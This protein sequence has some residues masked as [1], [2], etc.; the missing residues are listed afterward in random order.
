MGAPGVC[1]DAPKEASVESAFLL[2]ASAGEHCGATQEGGK[3]CCSGHK[4]AFE[5][6]SL[7]GAKGKCEVCA[8]KGQACGH[9]FE[10]QTEC[11][12]NQICSFR[13]DLMGAPGVCVDAPKEFAVESAFLICASVGE[14]CGS[15]REGGNEC[16]SGHKCV[17][18]NDGRLGAK[19][20]CEVCAVK[21][22]SCGH[23]FE[24][25][26]ECCSN[27]VCS[28]RDGLL[29][30]PG[31]CVDVTAENAV[32]SNFLVCA[33]AGEHC[34]VAQEGGNACC[35]GH[36]CVYESNGLVGSKGKCEVCAIKGQS[37]GHKVEGQL[38]C[39]SDQVC[40]FR[41]TLLGAP[42]VCVDAPKENSV[43]SSFLVCA[44]AGEHCGVTQEGGNECCSGHKC[45]YENNGLVGSKGRCEVCAVKGQSC[46]HKL[47]GQLECCSNQVCSFRGSLL[48]ASGV[49]VDVPKET[50][51]ESGFLVCASAGQ[52]CGVSQEGGKECCSGH[53]C[54]YEN[55]GLMGAKGRCELC[56]AKGQSCGHKSEGQ[57]ECCSGQV[58]SFRGTLLGAPGVC[59]D[60]PKET[61]VESSF[62]VCASAGEHCGSPQEGGKECCSG[63]KCIFESNGLVGGKGKCEVCAVKGKSCG[64]KVEGQL[65]CCFGQVC[66]F[67]GGLF[68]APGVCVD[69]PKENENLLCASTGE[70]CGKTEEGQKECCEG[71]ACT[72]KAGDLLGAPGTCVEKIH[73]VVLGAVDAAVCRIEGERCGNKLEGGA[74]CCEGLDCF[75][76]SRLLGAAGRCYR[77]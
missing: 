44:S 8:A 37:C 73:R 42:G 36:K 71:K 58:C 20:K 28:F 17:Y 76:E 11:C 34:G 9:K 69:A 39:C 53:K 25:Q 15:T 75:W 52:H 23:K 57:L 40:S 21:G 49:C 50:A 14:H 5:D 1:V 13:G 47:E 2:C 33:S 30:A 60:A 46:G 68:G 74:E 70:S 64:H 12:D 26:L 65:E 32:E 43:Q 31:L 48:G 62:L 63:H 6:D 29:G 77:K 55:N 56:S 66:S 51:V 45:V 27:Q 16:C 10:G 3:S 38:E 4:C 35:S 61:A 24:G 72:W 18:A 59:V 22:Q 7:L 41:G 54:V 19:G 67:R